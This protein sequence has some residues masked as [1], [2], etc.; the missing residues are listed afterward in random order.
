MLPP[1]RDW[2]V[3]Y[4]GLGALGI[5]RMVDMAPLAK[6]AAEQALLI[7]PA[8]SEAHSVLGLIA[9][10]VEYD[11]KSAERYFQASM[12]VDPVPPLVRVRFAPYFLTPLRRFE[13]RR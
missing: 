11:W 9:G 4:Y 12:A 7:D 10:S 2:E 8:L 1:T 6:S 3:F 5:K 13:E